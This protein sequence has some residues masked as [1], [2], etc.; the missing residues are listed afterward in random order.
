MHPAYIVLIVAS[1]MMGLVA[2]AFLTWAFRAGQMENFDR[3]AT[4][5]FD[6][7]EPLGDV[8]E[9]TLAPRKREHTHD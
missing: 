4:S 9:N 6:P 7:D 1:A 8:T 3:G 5:I 2:V